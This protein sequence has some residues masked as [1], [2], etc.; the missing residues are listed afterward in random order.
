[1]TSRE[2]KCRKAASGPT[3][4]GPAGPKG[5]TGPAG[6]P[7]PHGEPGPPGVVH[8]LRVP[9]IPQSAESGGDP[10]P[11]SGWSLQRIGA[12]NTALFWLH[13]FDVTLDPEIW[14]PVPLPES[15]AI[16]RITAHVLGQKPF[17]LPSSM[18]S[19]ALLQMP[20]SF[21]NFEIFEQV[22]LTT[23]P[24]AYGDPHVI[25][26]TTDNFGGNPLLISSDNNYWIRLSGEAGDNARSRR[27]K[28]TA[29]SITID[30]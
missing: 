6:P 27:L 10:S 26:L 2:A 3:C 17:P 24:D 15:G 16:R 19:L 23:D 18:P 5:D 12:P 30:P 13:Q 29:I 9:L 7:G 20:V 21:S 1:M 14:F 28:L 11:G 22:D 4:T 25:A 8:F